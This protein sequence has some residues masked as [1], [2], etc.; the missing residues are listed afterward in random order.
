MNNLSLL[1]F[2]LLGNRLRK[3]FQCISIRIFVS[4]SVHLYLCKSICTRT[5]LSLVVR[6][7]R[8]TTT[9]VYVPSL[10]LMMSI[11]YMNFYLLFLFGLTFSKVP[12]FQ[13]DNE[14]LNRTLYVHRARRETWVRRPGP[15][16]VKCKSEKTKPRK[17]KIK[18][19]MK[20]QKRVR[21]YQKLDGVAGRVELGDD[22]DH[23]RMRYWGPSL[24]YWLLKVRPPMIISADYVGGFI[25]AE[26]VIKR[27][28]KWFIESNIDR[29]RQIMIEGGGTVLAGTRLEMYTKLLS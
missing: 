24:I 8:S 20:T 10:L 22:R 6:P 1:G 14:R 21:S 5:T 29:M 13:K 4:V 2:I 3:R 18:L 17:N 9:A 26:C 25:I 12:M 7:S 15:S 16:L 27:S 19:Y 11:I 23:N 28:D